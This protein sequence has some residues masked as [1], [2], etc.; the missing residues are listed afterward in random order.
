MTPQDPNLDPLL[1]Q[2]IAEIRDEPIDP[3]VME[4][5]AHRVAAR[6]EQHAPLRGCADFQALIPEY[7]AG[8]LSAAR[9]LL[10][11]D[12]THECVACRKALEAASGKVT[13]MP[14]RHAR[15]AWS[16]M[17][18]FRWAIAAVLLLAA[19]LAFWAVGDRFRPSGGG[20]EAVVESA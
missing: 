6:L 10:L 8:T 15:R 3:A 20:P 16:D 17:P 14:V 7:R 12:H 2:A 19:G 1:E 18:G 11:K 4:A 13:A 5:A 9:A